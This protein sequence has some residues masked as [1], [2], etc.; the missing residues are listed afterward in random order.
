MNFHLNKQFSPRPSNTRFLIGAGNI[1][2]RR[3]F[4]DFI[5]GANGEAEDKHQHEPALSYVYYLIHPQIKR[6]TREL[7]IQQSGEK[8]AASRSYF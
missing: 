2:K 4:F 1:N 7:I 3:Q 6:I 5:R 8:S